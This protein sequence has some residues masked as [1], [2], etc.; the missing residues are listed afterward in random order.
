M[1][2]S[3]KGFKR[4]A[5]SVDKTT[6]CMAP[7]SSKAPAHLEQTSSALT[8]PSPASDSASE[9]KDNDSQ[10][11]LN[12]D[13]PSVVR[14]EVVVSKVRAKNNVSNGHRI[15]PEQFFYDMAKYGESGFPQDLM[16]RCVTYRQPLLGSIRCDFTGVIGKTTEQIKSNDVVS[17]KWTYHSGELGDMVVAGSFAS[18]HKTRQLLNSTMAIRTTRSMLDAVCVAKIYEKV[19]EKPSLLY[20]INK[21]CKKNGLD[22][23]GCGVLR[24][25]HPKPLITFPNIELLADPSGNSSKWFVCASVDRNIVLCHPGPVCRYTTNRCTYKKSEVQVFDLDEK[26]ECLAKT[27]KRRKRTIITERKRSFPTSLAEINDGS[28]RGLRDVFA[29]ATALAE[30]EL[31]KRE[32]RQ[33]SI[34]KA[35]SGFETDP[36]AWGNERIADHSLFVLWRS[37]DGQ[38]HIDGCTLRSFMTMIMR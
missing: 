22:I 30:F 32:V 15:I 17:F 2:C 33:V 20:F 26:Q 19:I 31:A 9:K 14:H 24:I 38:H 35:L 8:V 27:F 13:E 10:A 37:G 4:P 28:H 5:R 18:F 16:N 36:F 12:G 34:A 3:V 7:S 1:D 25:A 23:G 11:T 6:K 21:Y 29:Y